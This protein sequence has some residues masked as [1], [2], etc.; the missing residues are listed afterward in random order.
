MKC[1]CCGHPDGSSDGVGMILCDDC[2]YNGYRGDSRA[3]TG[4]TEQGQTVFV[5]ASLLEKVKD[6]L[7]KG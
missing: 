3:T 5:P 1:E 4:Q 6:V 2:Y 7:K